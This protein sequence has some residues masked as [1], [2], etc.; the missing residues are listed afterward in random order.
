M[1]INIRLSKNFTTQLN[2]LYEKYGEEFARLNGLSDDELSLTDFIDNFIDTE[3]VADASIDS[4][5]NV[6]TKYMNTLMN[7]MPK[8][9]RKLLCLHKI[10]YEINKRYGFKTANEWL[11]NEWSRALYMHDADTATF[12]H[13]CF[14]YDL[15]D[16]AEKY[17]RTVAQIILRWE[18][19]HDVVPLPKSVNPERIRSNSQLFDF[20]LS[21]DDMQMIDEIEPYGN[22]GHSPDQA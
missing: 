1:N 4:S 9:L 2:K 20:E 15:K 18:M 13:Y 19:Q 6:S 7:E 3:T 17:D 5:S 16:L 11:E 8:P 14:A 22:S 10:Y 12:K 21:E